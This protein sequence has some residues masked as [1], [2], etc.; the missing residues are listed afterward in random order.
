MSKQEAE[1]S[2]IVNA[3][4]CYKAYIEVHES[5]DKCLNDIV[6]S[7]CRKLARRIEKR[8]GWEHSDD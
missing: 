6:I 5:Y 7:R 8:N 4:D 2:T 3:L 1:D